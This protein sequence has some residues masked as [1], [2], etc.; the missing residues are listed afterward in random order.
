MLADTPLRQI[1]TASP[2]QSPQNSL[3]DRRVAIVGTLETDRLTR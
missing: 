3:L 2:A 1:L